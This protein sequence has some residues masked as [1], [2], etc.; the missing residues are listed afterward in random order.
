MYFV[1][2]SSCKAIYIVHSY[3]A[4]AAK[5]AF[6]HW[7]GRSTGVC[8]A[9]WNRPSTTVNRAKTK[10]LTTLSHIMWPFWNEFCDWL[11]NKTIGSSQHYGPMESNADAYR[12]IHCVMV[13]YAHHA[14]GCSLHTQL[15]HYTCYIQLHVCVLWRGLS[16]I[17]CSP[18]LFFGI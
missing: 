17:K 18:H 6:G 16:F 9:D 5:D 2:P 8:R 10:T 11:L 15:P 7:V 13:T 3:C 4:I 12:R 1:N 14:C